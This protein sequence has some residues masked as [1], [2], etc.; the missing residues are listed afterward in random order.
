MVLVL[1]TLSG[2]LT[3]KNAA[4]GLGEARTIPDV[5]F[6]DL[7]GSSV[8]LSALLGKVVLINFWGTW[9]VPCLKEIPELVNLSQRFKK[10]GFEVVGIAV[11]WS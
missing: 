6:E 7:N 2:P 3:T 10:K 5:T 4:S 11:E 1:L 8:S 9:C